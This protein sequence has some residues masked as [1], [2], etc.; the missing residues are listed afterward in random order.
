MGFTELINSAKVKLK[1]YLKNTKEKF[2]KFIHNHYRT[3]HTGRHI[4]QQGKISHQRI[5][6]AS[7]F[8]HNL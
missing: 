3:C 8:L 4:Q 7:H 6:H 2:A 1:S 5:L